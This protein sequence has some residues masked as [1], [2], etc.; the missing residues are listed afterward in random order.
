MTS[1]W[2]YSTSGTPSVN[3]GSATVLN[4]HNIELRSPSTQVLRH[5]F[6]TRHYQRATKQKVSVISDLTNTRELLYANWWVKQTITLS[7]KRLVKFN[8]ATCKVMWIYELKQ[9]RVSTARENRSGQNLLV[10]CTCRIEDWTGGHRHAVPFAD[11]IM[12]V[13][14]DSPTLL[15]I[16]SPLMT[17][18]L[19]RRRRYVLC[20]L[21]FLNTLLRAVSTTVLWVISSYYSLVDVLNIL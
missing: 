17:N 1:F 9:T 2:L 6:D 7:H 20:S 5:G 8:I 18:V 12:L 13:R 3:P 4:L 14:N 15:V 11:N 19:S 10:Y 16:F 21:I